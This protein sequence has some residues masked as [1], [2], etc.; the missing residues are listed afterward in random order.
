MTTTTKSD[1]VLRQVLMRRDSGDGV[2]LED[3]YWIFNELAKVGKHVVDDNGAEWTIIE[4]YGAKKF[5][6]VDKQR[7]AWKIWHDKLKD[8]C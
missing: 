8:H 1:I 3:V 7:D 6:D 2:A 5:D 4:T